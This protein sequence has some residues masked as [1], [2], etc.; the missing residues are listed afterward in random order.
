MDSNI[1]ENLQSA[2]PSSP[3]SSASKLIDPQNPFDN[4]LE[5]KKYRTDYR[6]ILPQILLPGFQIPLHPEREERRAIRK[7]MNAAGLGVFLNCLLNQLLFELLAL[8]ILFLMNGVANFGEGRFT[9][10]QVLQSS[11][12]FM[13]L[14]SVV[15]AGLNVTT[16]LLGCRYMH[17]PVRNLFQTQDFTAGKAVKYMAIGIGLQCIAGMVYQL[18]SWIME[19]NGTELVETDFSYFQSGK[20]IITTM[21]YTCI[22]APITEELLYR[23]FVMKTLSQVSV[24]FGI[25]VSALLFGMMHGNLNQFMLGALVGLF[26]GKIDVRHN[27]IFPSILVHM[28]I[29]TNSV[30]LSFM[31]ELL[32]GEI[33]VLIFNLISFFCL[34]IALIGVIFWFLTERKEPLPYPTQKQATRNRVFWSSP[35]LLAAFA[36]L[37]TEM[38]YM[39]Y[40]TNR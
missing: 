20:S 38:A 8:M 34:A 33:G 26:L 5:N 36:L 9:A 31:Q 14:H 4:V 19:Q 12:S 13:A 28:A 18:V 32:T 11:S 21:L 7:N 6:R 1:R 30:L 25:V 37:L 3:E 35:C 23:G 15:F 17:I 2:S 29:N 10:Y 22:L 40:Y 27:S 16:A 24:R 39:A